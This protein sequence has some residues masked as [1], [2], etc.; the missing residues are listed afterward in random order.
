MKPVLKKL[1]S[2]ELNLFVSV[3][4]ITGK[5]KPVL[6]SI[7]KKESAFKPPQTPQ[8]PVIKKFSSLEK[9]NN[10]TSTLN[11]NKKASIKLQTS[12]SPQPLK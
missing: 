2:R 5:P 10:N 1:N 7:F 9:L 11:E 6:K 8:Q 3:D 4:L 12:Q